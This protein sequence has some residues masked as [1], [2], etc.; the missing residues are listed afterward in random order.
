M[1]LDPDIL[2][3]KLDYNPTTGHFSLRVANQTM[4]AGY[5][6]TARSPGQYISVPYGKKRARAGRA[7]YVM[8]TGEQPDHIDHING[9]PHD[10][11]WCN[12]RSVTVTENNR[13][14][15]VHRIKN[16]TYVSLE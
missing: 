12:L 4:P 3:S 11:R 15:A 2:R 6:Y 10:N 1:Y 5:I 8:M 7:A 14:K 16:G 13:N 9:L